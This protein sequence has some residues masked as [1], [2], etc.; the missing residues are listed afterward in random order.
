MKWGQARKRKLP[1]R[2]PVSVGRGQTSI[3]PESDFQAQDALKIVDTCPLPLF[4]ETGVF[5][6]SA[7]S[8]LGVQ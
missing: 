6:D 3:R 8:C 7:R 5:H 1:G 4:N 2:R